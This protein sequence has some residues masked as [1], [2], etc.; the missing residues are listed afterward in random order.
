MKTKPE[1]KQLC[2]VCGEEATKHVG[3][4]MGGWYCDHCFKV[5]TRIILG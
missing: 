3:G 5:T 2:C 1:A 4:C